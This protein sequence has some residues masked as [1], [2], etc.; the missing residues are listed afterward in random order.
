MKVIEL[1]LE[2]RV[3]T[4]R[5]HMAV[6]DYTDLNTTA[7]TGKTLVLAPYLARDILERGAYDLVTPFVGAAITN[8]TAK[9][10][11]NGATTDGADSLFEAKELAG[12][13][14]EILSDAGSIDASAIDAT[15]GAPELA[16][17]TSLRNRQAYAPQ[18]AGNV[19]IVFTATGANLTA[20]TAGK[21]RV[22]FNVIRLTDLRGINGT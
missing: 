6:I 22:L 5:S 16:V 21:V 12:V 9:L 13:A 19:E 10:G 7:G 17:L 18:D 15:F 14:T 11:Y 3:K 8:L 1:T 2:E 20:L 4:G